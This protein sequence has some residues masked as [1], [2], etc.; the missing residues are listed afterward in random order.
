MQRPGSVADDGYFG[1]GDFQAHEFVF[2]VEEQKNFE[3]A[4]GDLEAFVGLALRRG[5][6]GGF[7][8]D[9]AGSKLLRNQNLELLRAAFGP[10]VETG[11]HGVLVVEIV[12]EDGHHGGAEGKALLRSEEHTS[13]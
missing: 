8:G 3:V 13:E 9:V 11:E 4:R 10:V 12:V 7:E 6:A 2:C 5:G 1:G